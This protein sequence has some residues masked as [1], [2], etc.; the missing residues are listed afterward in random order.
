M[1]GEKQKRNMRT[2]KIRGGGTYQEG[3]RHFFRGEEEGERERERK[4]KRKRKGKGKGKGEEE[5]E[6]EEEEE[7]EDEDEDEGEGEG[8]GEGDVTNLSHGGWRSCL[9]IFIITCEIKSFIS[10]IYPIYI[11]YILLYHQYIIQRFL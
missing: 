4:R 6:E 7:G 8:E 3:I 9:F 2:K 5:E 1:V 10:P 11:Q